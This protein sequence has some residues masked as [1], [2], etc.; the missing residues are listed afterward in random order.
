MPR[1]TAKV[2][3]SA[4]RTFCSRALFPVNTPRSTEFYELRMAPRGV[5][6]AEPHPPGTTENLVVASGSIHIRVRSELYQLGIGDAILFDADVPHEYRNPSADVEAL[7][8]LVM[9]YT[10]PSR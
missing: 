9:T 6:S 3:L 8:F 10:E 2:L 7:M 5:E 1:A 4:D